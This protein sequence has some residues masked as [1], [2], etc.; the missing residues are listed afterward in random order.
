[1]EV[2]TAMSLAITSKNQAIDWQ[3]VAIKTKDPQTRNDII[4]AL[5]I[6]KADYTLIM[7]AIIRHR[8]QKFKGL[9]TASPAYLIKYS[10]PELAFNALGMKALYYA[11]GDI[12]QA[13][14]IIQRSTLYKQR[15][16]ILSWDWDERYKMVAVQRHSQT[17]PDSLT[18]GEALLESLK[19]KMGLAAAK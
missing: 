10:K 3:N 11:K 5:W 4:A 1:M 16:S 15:K 14:R 12:K 8:D 18:Q 19:A 17:I 9:F 7:N 2:S 13:N 6:F